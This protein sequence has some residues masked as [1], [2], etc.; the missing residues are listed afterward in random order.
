MKVRPDILNDGDVIFVSFPYNPFYVL[1]TEFHHRQHHISGYFVGSDSIV[2]VSMPTLELVMV[3]SG[4]TTARLR[5]LSDMRS[6]AA[7]RPRS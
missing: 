6:W 7:R 1:G 3:R 4:P 2:T 5:E